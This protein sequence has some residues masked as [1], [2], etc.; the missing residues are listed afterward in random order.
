MAV[1]LIDKAIDAVVGAYSG[2][3]FDTLGAHDAGNGQVVIRA[4]RPIAHKLYVVNDETRERTEMKRIRE[5][6]F[7]EATIE[8]SPANLRYH[9]RAV[10]VTGETEILADPYAFR[11][12]LLT[13]YDLHLFGEG[14]LLYSYEK[15]GAQVRDIDGVKGVNFAVWAPNAYRVSVVGEFNRWDAR[16]HPMQSRGAS[17]VWELFIP[18]LEPGETY[19]YD[20]RSHNQD[21]HGV[22][23][24]PYGFRSERRPHTASIVTDLG[25]Y[26]WQDSAWIDQRSVE[27]VLNGPVTI[28]EVHLG[29]W[30]R[31]EEGTF[32]TYRELA[33]QLVP[34]VK[35]MGYTHIELLPVLEHPLDASWG[36]QVT[37]YYAAT[38][39]YGTPQ[40][41]MYF[42]DVC[43]QNGI[44]VILDWVPAHF[45]KDGFGLSYFDGTHLYSH[46]NDV[47]REHPDWGTYIFNY[48]R[49]EVRNFLISN[50]LF[51]LDKYH[52][53]GLRVD[54]V[55]S[56]LYLSFGR[57]NGGWIPNEYG[58]AENLEAIEFL[59]EVNTVVHGEFP[60]AITIAEESTSWPMV[61]RPTYVGGLGFTLK[62]NMG[63]MHDTLKF[64]KLDPLYRRWK[65]NTITF[66]IMYAFSE[67]FVLPLS[68]DEVVHLKKSMLSKMAGDWW[69]KFASLRLTYG[70]QMTHPGKK[71]TFMGMEIGQW[72]EWTEERE[73][74]WY[75][76]EWPNHSGL[77]QF[78][79]DLNRVYK[80]HPALWQHDF[81]ERGFRWID[82]D[83]ADQSILTYMRFGE[84]PDNFVVVACNFTPVPREGYRVGV[85]ESGYY[86][87]LINSD[88]E[89]YGGSNL[90]NSGG[91]HTEAHHSHG[92]DQSLALTLPPLAV[93]ILKLERD[94]S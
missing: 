15:L 82:A 88:S 25:G 5:E 34:Y 84:D 47:R 11:K 75:L 48:G 19:K 65:H 23:A 76:L 31:N 2:S 38:S 68:H 86:R 3:P 4:F 92:Y 1:N 59:R 45:P 29:S 28:Y 39:R 21:Y 42:V 78:V 77:Q 40:D 9:Y 10:A 35:D 54:A 57:E 16:A 36:Y 80:Q 63:W 52:V 85:P 67:N 27:G 81:D 61:S 26:D 87:E 24:D 70:Y 94:Y 72:A 14:R 8:G 71:L 22:K 17:G 64:M 73:L 89:I 37:G 49:N 66:S 13:D 90:G 50:A 12:P 51:W 7:F 33:D 18:G 60:G 93:V 30:K 58:G 83:D 6:G 69:Q 74:D 91:V 79:R 43:H 55:S 32:L 46:E 62:W 41:F 20:L 53:D 44:G 56:M